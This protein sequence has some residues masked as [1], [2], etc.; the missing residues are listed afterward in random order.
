[1]DKLKVSEGINVKKK[2]H[3]Q[4]KLLYEFCSKFWPWIAA[5]GVFVFA[6]AFS[7]LIIFRLE[8]DRFQLERAYASNIASNYTGAVKFTVEHTL[9]VAYALAALVQQDNGAI[10]NFEELAKHMLSLY[11]GADSLQLAPG[12][13]VQTIV[14]LAGN[15]KAMGHDLLS[16][17]ERSAEAVF[18]RDSGQLTLAGPFPMVQG[19]FLGGVGRLPVF[20][21]DREGRPYFWGF[22]N[23][24]IRFP[25]VLEP[26]RLPQL[27]KQGFA[28][29]LWCIRPGTDQRQVIAASSAPLAANPVERPFQVSNTTWTLSVTP[30]NGWNNSYGLFLRILQGFIF[31]LL[32]AWLTKLM[33]DL[34][35]SKRRLEG[36]AFLDTLTGLPNRRL[37]NDRLRQAVIRSRRTHTLVGVCFLDLDDFKAINDLFGHK[38]GDELLVELAARFAGCLRKSDTLARLGGDEFVAVL[39]DLHREEECITAVSRLLQSATTPVTDRKSVV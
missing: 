26:A 39:G 2:I 4:I 35:R 13:V 34:K 18:T 3:C 23:V 1:M 25:D 31:S 7:A 24:A 6:A 32:L 10:S 8:Q 28:Y 33:I 36:I 30:I 14:P 16:D 21:N 11:P 19:P 38:A 9:S 12:G 29:K 17:P 22:V 15:E 5:A 20:F 27:E 37:L